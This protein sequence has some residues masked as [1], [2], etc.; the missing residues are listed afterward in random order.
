[1]KTD[2][3]IPLA[4]VHGHPLFS[5]RGAD[6][7]YNTEGD[8]LRRTADG[9]DLNELW[10]EFNATLEI[11]NRR[12]N[13]LMQILTFPVTQMIERVPQIGSF[14]FDEA[15]EFGEPTGGRVEIGIFSLGYDFR[16]YDKAT[17]YT[18]K[19]LRDAP[20]AHIEAIHNAM[21]EAD[22]R[23]LFRKVMEAIFDN[24]NRKAEI[25]GNNY[26]VYSLYNNDGTVPPPYKST[27]F[28]ST[29]TH[30]K[31]SG[32]VLIDSGDVEAQYEMIREHGYGRE[33]GTTFVLFGN[34]AETEEIRKFR[35]G[36][37]NNNA[38]VANYDFIPSSAQPALV[39]PN[40]EGLLGELPPDSFQGLPVLGSYAGILI[41]EEDYIPA[42][43]TLMIGS[44]GEGNLQNP[45]GIREHAN[46]AYRGLRLMPGNQQGYPLQ[47]AFYARAFGTG[48]RQRGGASVMQYKVGSGTL[49]DYD[50]PDGYER[51]LGLG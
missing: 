24:R 6:E 44:G 2:T 26:T 20:A 39:I 32:N 34:R 47:D 28:P 25:E 30:Y 13:T 50:I 9:Y 8:L 41:V 3:R 17:R 10:G 31:V 15:S 1:M 18:W 21:I 38:V 33:Q 37:A 48:I 5:V 43:Y 16:D 11:L 7:G 36:V 14:D 22:N 42:G 4:V 35:R 45:V 49:L 19:F 27:T 23:L 51:G 12:R 29:H 40:A 46:P